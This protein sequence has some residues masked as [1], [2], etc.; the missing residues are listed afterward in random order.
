M[1]DRGPAMNLRKLD[2]YLR[3]RAIISPWQLA[4]CV[5]SDFTAA[6][7]IPALAE[8]EALPQTLAALNRN[9]GDFLEQTLILIVVNQRS[10]A[11]EPQKN[12]NQRTLDW[13][14]SIPYP[15][16]NLAWV[17]AASPGLELPDNDGVGLARKIGFDLVLKH[18]D[19]GCDPLLISLDADTLVAANY[20]PA[21]F[22]HFR[23]DSAA[24]V[25]LPFRHQA[26]PTLAE[27]ESIRCYELYLRSYLFGLQWAGSPYAFTSIGSALACRA[28]AY[29]A[30]GGMKKKQAGEDF[31]FLQQLVK[32]G[33]LK[34]LDGTVVR[35]SPRFS[36]RVPFGTGRTVQSEVEDGK[37][38]YLFVSLASF[39]I[40]RDWLTLVGRST[41]LTAVEVLRHAEELSP[42]LGLFL[43]EIDFA[44]A[45]H[46]LLINNGPARLLAAWHNW[47]DGLRTRQ[48]LGRLEER[49]LNAD[50]ERLVFELLEA[51]GYPDQT[52]RSQ[53]L[54]LLEQLQ[55]VPA[56]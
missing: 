23:T 37:R 14:H 32:T 53:Q 13:L 55:G 50:P 30:A 48:L 41:N 47:F 39:R 21:I 12:N 54:Q 49:L 9:P 17:D 40:L 7:V 16:L 34:P 10:A 29:V 1:G 24:G 46:K 8:A 36:A 11:A 6:V 42:E 38:L 4:G 19:P 28:A 18:L 25:Y 43:N 33:T 2:K 5:R 45:W 31:Y 35:P 22:A 52:Q 15:G 26:A 56:G 20:L 3:N 44:E 51:G 27:E